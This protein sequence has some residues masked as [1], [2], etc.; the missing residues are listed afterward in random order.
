MSVSLSLFCLLG[1]LP[2]LWYT[3]TLDC[4]VAPNE[5]H[6]LESTLLATNPHADYGLIHV[7]CF[8]QQ[9]ASEG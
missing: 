1:F 9:N 7:I 3:V 6:L 2:Q 4:S 5:S 8:G